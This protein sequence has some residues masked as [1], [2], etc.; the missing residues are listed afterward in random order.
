MFEHTVNLEDRNGCSQ[1]VTVRIQENTIEIFP[2]GYGDFYSEDG[3]G[4]PVMVELREGKLRLLCWS[5]INVEDAK[6]TS[7]EDARENNRIRELI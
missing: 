4:C 7:L 3:F 6:I 5:D 1:E 2:K